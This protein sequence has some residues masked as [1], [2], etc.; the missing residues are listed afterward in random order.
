[1]RIWRSLKKNLKNQASDVL[2]NP[3]RLISLII[4]ILHIKHEIL[5]VKISIAA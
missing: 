5:V 2:K 3:K 1:M 4:S